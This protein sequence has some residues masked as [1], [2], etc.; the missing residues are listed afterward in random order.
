MSDSL[1]EYGVERVPGGR[2]CSYDWRIRR[3]EA[4]RPLEVAIISPEWFG[5]R[6]HYFYGRTMPHR[7]TGVCPG[8]AGGPSRWSGYLLAW[9]HG[10][11]ERIIWE[12]TP[13]VYDPLESLLREYGTLRGIYIQ[14]T[15]HKKVPNGRLKIKALGTYGA[16]SQLPPPQAIPPLVF[17]IW[18]IPLADD[19]DSAAAAP[20]G[21]CPADK[22]PRDPGR[23]RRQIEDREPVQ[24]VQDLPGQ[25]RLLG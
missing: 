22:P 15:R 5:I 10:A 11:S 24:I 8:C 14:V 21:P 4:S 17:R 19:G 25:M 2:D 7:T 18:G 20:T 9:D 16:A 23:R 1:N 12:F 6:V 3:A 13:A